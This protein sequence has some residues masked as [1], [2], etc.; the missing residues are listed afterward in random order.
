MV[1]MHKQNT[2]AKD[3]IIGVPQG[4]V[5]GPTLGD[6]AQAKYTFKQKTVL[7][8]SPREQSLD[9]PMVIMDHK[10]QYRLYLP[11]ILNK[12]NAV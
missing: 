11:E 3:S 6:H 10:I 2:R 9:L 7:L 8:V 12:Q 5:L 4:K 1:I